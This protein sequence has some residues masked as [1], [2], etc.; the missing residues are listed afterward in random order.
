[1]TIVL[2]MKERMIFVAAVVR[3]VAA[4]AETIFCGGFRILLTGGVNLQTTVLS[5][6]V[7]YMIRWQRV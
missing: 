4:A 7:G 1:M 3:V 5:W 6:T 2:V